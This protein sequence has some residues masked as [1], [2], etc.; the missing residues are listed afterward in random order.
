MST[1]H[2][3][4]PPKSTHFS[5]LG[6]PRALTDVQIAD[7]LAWHASRVSLKQKAAEH[8]VSATV[9]RHVIRT[10]GK[11]YKQASP[12]QRAKNLAADRQRRAYLY[13]TGWL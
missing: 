3:R 2:P 12:E 5:T 13:E 7:I 8:G 1:H 9:I 4:S 11:T 10:G 6:R